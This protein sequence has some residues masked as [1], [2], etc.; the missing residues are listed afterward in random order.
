MLDKD[1]V[2]HTLR[3]HENKI[4]LDKREMLCFSFEG[5]E[6]YRGGPT[7]AAPV[8]DGANCQNV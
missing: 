7:E 5:E 3:R 6:E 2:H 4:E 1:K 8:R